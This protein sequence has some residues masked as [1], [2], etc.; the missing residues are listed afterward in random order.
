LPDSEYP[1]DHTTVHYTYKTYHVLNPNEP[2]DPANFDL[3]DMDL[4]GVLL[5]KK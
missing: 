5:N 1:Y 3:L 2:E 4:E